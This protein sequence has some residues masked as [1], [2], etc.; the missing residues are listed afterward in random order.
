MSV[1]V[2]SGWQVV[3]LGR[4]AIDGPTNGYSP[5]SAPDAA[6]TRSLKLSATTQ[7][8][9]VLSGATI[10]YLH[11]SIAPDSWVWLAPG[12]LL[13]QRSNTADLVG[14]AAIFDG[15]PHAYI[16]PDLMMRL[17]FADEATTRWVWRYLNSPGGRHFFGAMAAGSAGSMPKISG[18]KL[19]S[20]PIPLPPLPEL[21]RIADILDKADAIRRKRKEAI[22]FTEELLRSAFLEMFGDPVTNPKGWDVKPLGT[23]LT[24]PLRN[25]LSPASG[26][27]H[28]ANV[29]TLSAITRGRFDESAVKYGAFALEPW[30]DVRLDERDFLIC[31]GNGN[32]AMVGTG[33]FPTSS[34]ATV[35]FPDTMIAARVDETRVS[36]AFLNTVWKSQLVR[37]QVEAGARTTNGTFKV[38]QTLVESV[39][40]PVPALRQQRAFDAAATEVSK[41]SEKLVHASQH[42]CVLFDSL[43][44]RAFRGE[45]TGANGGSKPQLGFFDAGA[46]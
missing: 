9:L 27:A 38:N 7:G 1:R 35:V 13:V 17:R 16:Y 46:R 23:L 43:V 5:E 40:I 26:G 22:G 45:L 32:L 20:M 15:P 8:R 42:A 10:K 4:L 24:M 18:A 30:D 31:R 39:S 29:L 36:R 37:R 44:H 41:L 14:T 11:E 21:R 19:K 12:D 3:D 28:A 6:G 34:D 33:A 2:P 25:G